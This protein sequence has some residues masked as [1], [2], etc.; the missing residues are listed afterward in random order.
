M[1]LIRKKRALMFWDSF[2]SLPIRLSGAEL[3]LKMAANST[4]WKADRMKDGLEEGEREKRV[5]NYGKT[6]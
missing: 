2:I 6:R 5:I 4:Y 3:E 1:T